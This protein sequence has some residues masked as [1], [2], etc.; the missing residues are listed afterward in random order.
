MSW[1]KFQPAT[2]KSKEEVALAKKSGWKT[3]ETIVCE[4]VKQSHFVGDL[5]V[6]ANGRMS[7]EWKPDVPGHKNPLSK[8]GLQQY[9]AARNRRLQSLA[10]HIGGVIVVA[11]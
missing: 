2:F 6:Y 9:Q 11:E 8:P 7:C 10:D 4:G 3:T 1:K 5:I